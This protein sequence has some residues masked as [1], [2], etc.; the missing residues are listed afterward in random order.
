MAGKVSCAICGGDI[1]ISVAE[2]MGKCT[3]CGVVYE[4]DALS[5]MSKQAAA[6]DVM[7]SRDDESMCTMTQTA[8]TSSAGA[9]ATIRSPNWNAADYPPI[10]SP[11]PEVVSDA[12][13]A[14]SRVVPCKQDVNARFDWETPYLAS[15]MGLVF[16]ALGAGWVSALMKADLVGL[17]LGLVV[18]VLY[19]VAAIV[20]AGVYYPTLFTDKPKVVSASW[21]GFWNFFLGGWLF[22]LI[23][24]H[25]LTLGKK[26][27]SY[28]VLMI[29][30]A[31]VVTITLIMGMSLFSAYQSAMA[32]DVN[33]RPGDEVHFGHTGFQPMLWRVIDKTD[34]GKV[35]L[36]SVDNVYQDSVPGDI[37][38]FSQLR[39]SLN[40]H[41]LSEHFNG[42]EQTAIV[43][44]PLS[45]S[46][47]VGSGEE[48]ETEE[49]AS[50]TDRV[51]LLSADEVYDYIELLAGAQAD[52]I[53]R[54]S[55]EGIDEN[56]NL[57]YT[58][59]WSVKEG[60]FDGY[61]HGVTTGDKYG[62]RPAIVVDTAML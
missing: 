25:N 54:D 12:E 18:V 7:E 34:D 11:L 2:G 58:G 42:G 33:S 55:I 5:T 51:F 20:W 44:V 1:S 39:T 59:S 35:L 43:P 32:L 26:S 57:V 23:W 4:F 41:F 22:G 31:M 24:N 56:G 37:W 47:S 28:V 17:S 8:A 60:R 15:I 53:L 45:N 38:E 50:T 48:W 40:N 3:G 21:V 27:V 10:A 19:F 14:S 36:I 13:N 62:I 9:A 52:W 46:K 6:N 29:G 49:L 30:N 61:T 16:C